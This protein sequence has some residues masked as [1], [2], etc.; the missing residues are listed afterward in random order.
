VRDPDPDPDS[1]EPG[2][3]TLP[4][5]IVVVVFWLEQT[6]F[7]DPARI[8]DPHH[9]AR[10]QPS[11]L[12]WPLLQQ[13]ICLSKR[14]LKSTKSNKI[15]LI[16]PQYRFQ[17][18]FTTGP[19]RIREAARIRKATLIQSKPTTPRKISLLQQSYPVRPLFYDCRS[20]NPLQHHIQKYH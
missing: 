5:S 19:I 14:L 6:G 3:T 2:P 12:F 18:P 13:S 11:L 4:F 15:Q 20:I 1:N 17:L 7:P 16:L 8:P 9:T 10:E